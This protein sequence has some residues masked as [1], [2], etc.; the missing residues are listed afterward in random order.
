MFGFGY[1]Y[2]LSLTQAPLF[3]KR[4]RKV[5]KSLLSIPVTNPKQRSMT[6]QLY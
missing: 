1:I 6:E 3:G 5:I 4:S 2:A